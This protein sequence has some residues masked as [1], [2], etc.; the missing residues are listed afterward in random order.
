MEILAF[1]IGL[2]QQNKRDLLKFYA[3]TLGGDLCF[4]QAFIL[5]LK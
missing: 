1:N 2:K 3:L 4:W 5:V